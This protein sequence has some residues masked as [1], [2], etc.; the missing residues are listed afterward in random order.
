[1]TLLSMNEI[2]TFRWSLEEDI[3]HYQQAGY[4]SI[5]VWRQKLAD[6]DEER[7][8]E[9]LVTSGLSISNLL[10]A[11]G[12]TGSDGRSLEESIDDAIHAVRLAAA[13]KAGCLVIYPG[14]RNNHTYRHAGRILRIA[15][16]EL[17][18]LA[19]S[20]EVPLAVKPMHPACAADWTFLTDL[21]SVVT[22]I[23][24]VQ[25]DYLK[26]AYDTYH[27]PL[28][29]RHRHLLAALAPHIGI[30]HLGDRRLP[31]SIDQ[32]CCPLT[33]G[34]VPLGE[35]VTAL[36]EFGYSGPFDVKL[37]GTDIEANDYWMLLEQSQIAFAELAHAPAPGSVA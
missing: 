14:G 8:I 37:M 30:V 5:G 2:T 33:Q 31:P 7:G 17:L 34:R 16:D 10:W 36:Q 9:L 23:R 28:G 13:L 32:Q 25:S 27:F 19:E 4:H 18:P 1:M 29:R 11:G 15:L 22:L 6:G 3:E 12:F 21:E 26:I 20:A 24:A 35:I